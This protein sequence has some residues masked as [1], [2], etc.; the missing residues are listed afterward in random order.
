[1]IVMN[2]D[3]ADRFIR[4]LGGVQPGQHNVKIRN[5]W[6][7]DG[8]PRPVIA[9]AIKPGHE[10]FFELPATFEG[11]EVRRVPWKR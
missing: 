7:A 10:D 1:M 6:N 8:T 4:S 3:V 9:I 2:K 5:E 11:Y